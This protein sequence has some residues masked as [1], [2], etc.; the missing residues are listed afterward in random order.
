MHVC[1]SGVRPLTVR[2]GAGAPRC[3][4]PPLPGASGTRPGSACPRGAWG[5][6]AGVRQ[7]GGRRRSS[8]RAPSAPRAAVARRKRCAPGAAPPG[9]RPTPSNHPRT[10]SRSQPRNSRSIRAE[11]GSST[12][13]A[14]AGPSVRQWWRWRPPTSSPLLHC[15]TWPA[16]SA[17]SSLPSSSSFTSYTHLHQHNSMRV[18]GGAQTCG[19][20]D[21]NNC[22]LRGSQQARRASWRPA[23][24]PA[25]LTPCAGRGA[26]C[27]RCWQTGSPRRPPTTAAPAWRVAWGRPAGRGSRRA[28]ALLLLLGQGLGLRLLPRAGDG[29]GDANGVL[30]GRARASTQ[31][32]HHARWRLRGGWRYSGQDARRRIQPCQVPDLQA[33]R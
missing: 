20:G 17:L 31:T 10:H 2:S 1:P 22:N 21:E 26:S 30:A 3:P 15:R 16:W 28:C 4:A 18:E 14:K 19:R 23:A 9:S 25:P 29:C 7:A 12:L 8:S 27:T 11:A 24:A 33:S 5:R 32:V 13:G 6:P